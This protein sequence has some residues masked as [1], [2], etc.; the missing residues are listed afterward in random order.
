MASQSGNEGVPLHGNVPMKVASRGGCENRGRQTF[1]EGN[2]TT[3]RNGTVPIRTL[4]VLSA[5]TGNRPRWVAVCIEQHRME[6]QNED[7][8][9]YGRVLAS[10]IYRRLQHDRSG[11]PR[12]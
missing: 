8:T 2:V 10:P 1:Q 5:L 6:N 12:R 3:V 7:I 9:S 4:W 11:T